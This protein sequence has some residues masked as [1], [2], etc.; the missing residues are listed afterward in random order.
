MGL[1]KMLKPNSRGDAIAIPGVM[2]MFLSVVVVTIYESCWGL[3]LVGVGFLLLGIGIRID[4]KKRRKE[5]A[6]QEGINQTEKE[7]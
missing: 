4:D 1:K 6:K 3:I 2:L 7:D 5:N